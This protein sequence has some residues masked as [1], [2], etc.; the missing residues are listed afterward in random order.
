M[1]ATIYHP[2]K[3]YHLMESSSFSAID[4]FKSA[5]PLREASCYLESNIKKSW[6]QWLGCDFGALRICCFS[7]ENQS[8][9]RMCGWI[10]SHFSISNEN[11]LSLCKQSPKISLG[12]LFKHEKVEFL[13]AR[14]SVVCFHFHPPTVLSALLGDDS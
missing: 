13:A 11:L 5:L 7:S 3:S 12:C 10:F 9:S 1:K 4:I 2:W 6:N 8:R 14:I